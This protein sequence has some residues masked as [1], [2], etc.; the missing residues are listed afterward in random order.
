MSE[1]KSAL[2][3]QEQIARIERELATYTK[4]RQEMRLAPWQLVIAGMTVGAA[5]FAAGFALG[6]LL[7]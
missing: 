2:D 3:I 1:E 6:K 4:L 7:R 5:F